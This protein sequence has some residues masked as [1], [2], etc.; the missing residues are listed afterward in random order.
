M[1]D[2][3]IKNKMISELKTNSFMHG[4]Y[5]GVIVCLIGDVIGY[6]IFKFS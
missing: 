3:E 5:C 4:F 1:N 2:L 6:Y